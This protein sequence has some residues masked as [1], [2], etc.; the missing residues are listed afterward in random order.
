MTEYTCE[1]CGK[2][3]EVPGEDPF[4]TITVSYHDDDRDDFSESVCQ[5]CGDELLAPIVAEV[6]VDDQPEADQDDFD[7]AWDDAKT[8][9][10]EA[11]W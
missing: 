11:E 6:V 9:G 4:T 3:Y 1:R 8:N 2:T 7:A 5:E 10:T